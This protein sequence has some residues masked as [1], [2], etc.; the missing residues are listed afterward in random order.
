MNLQK[1]LIP[2]VAGLIAMGAA[3]WYLFPRIHYQP[4]LT[5][6]AIYQSLDDLADDKK[7]GTLFDHLKQAQGMRLDL[8]HRN[9]NGQRSIDIATT[10]DQGLAAA[11]FIVAG[12]GINEV[13]GDGDTVMHIAVHNH[14]L[15]VIKELA[16]FMP[17]LDIRNKAGLTAIEMAQRQGDTDTLALLTGKLTSN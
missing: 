10:N 8:N 13:N 12:S 6:D 17:R 1:M 3:G 5:P 2:L 11:A 16:H 15:H 7:M 14:S 9:I 4:E